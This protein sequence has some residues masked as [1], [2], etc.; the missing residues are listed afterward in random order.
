MLSRPLMVNESDYSGRGVL[1]EAPPPVLPL[2]PDGCDDS[3]SQTVCFTSSTPV[4]SP[5]PSPPPP[6][7]SIP[8]LTPPPSISS[9][10]PLPCCPCSSLL[11]RLLLAH[12]L[13]VRRLL[14]GA[15]SSLGRRLDSLERRSRMTRRKRS[16]WEG[17][18]GGACS[19]SVESTASSSSGSPAFTSSSATL[20]VTSSL[21]SSLD[22]EECPPFSSLA[23]PQ[24]RRGR[25]GEEVKR[26]RRKRR[27]RAGGGGE[28]EEEEEGRFVGRM[29]VSFRGGGEEAPLIL[30]NF[31]H[32]R[33]EEG[34]TGSQSEKAIVR[35]NGYQ[36]THLLQSSSSHNALQILGSERSF[37]TS[38]SS[39][40]WCFPDVTP[41]PFLSSNHTAFRPFFGSSSSFS[42]A[43]M[44]RLSVVAM[45]M[46]LDSVRGGACW[47]PLRPLKDWTAPPSLSSD[48][49]YVRP[50]ALSSAFSARR[51][52]KQR[53]NHS[54]RH[55]L[56]WR[57]PLPLPESS[58]NELPA[59]LAAGQSAAGSEFLSGTR[60]AGKRVSQ[61]RIRRASP[62]ETL[63]TPMGLPKVKRLKKKEF[64][65][66]EIYTNKNYKSP[67]SNRSLETIFEEP[68]EKDG[69]LLL[70]GQQRRRR[71][72]LFP[73]FTQPRKRKRPQG[74]GLPVA[75]VP[76][77][78]MAGRRHCHGNGCGDDE[79]DL[80][81]ML[82]ERLSA[83]EDFLTRQGLD[84]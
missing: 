18:G 2:A 39:K 9:S 82:V 49:C 84:V 77:K 6:P 52:Q 33:R 11:P 79:A 43:P 15:L 31:N 57:R 3:E 34:R 46:V 28:A 45:E 64:S 61:I 70:I 76:R 42:P 48:H 53:A 73:D 47:S 30:H 37:Q 63:L 75:M 44:L 60:E 81:V 38:S 23:S 80:D 67:T 56:P 12:Q 40:V 5:S 59:G 25:L 22:R 83:L 35:K 4:I 51:Q 54:A 62:R 55:R 26:R 36:A 72:L 19:S 17:G 50:P 65:L 66:E 14:R 21:S 74:V 24:Q 68:R 69:A 1:E 13:E 27:N 16:R 20:H 41:P 78:R 58:A 71:L 10:P 32:R 29:V 8:S 7:P